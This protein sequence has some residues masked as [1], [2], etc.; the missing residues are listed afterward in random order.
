[1]N[2]PVRRRPRRAKGCSAMQ[3][4]GGGG[5]HYRG[6]WCCSAGAPPGLQALLRRTR[7]EIKVTN[8]A[9]QLSADKGR[10]RHRGCE[11]ETRG[12]DA[13]A[14][15]VSSCLLMVPADR[16]LQSTHSRA[17]N[18]DSNKWAHM[19]AQRQR[20][21]IFYSFTFFF[22]LSLLKQATQHNSLTVKIYIF[23]VS[24]R[25]LSRVCP[26]AWSAC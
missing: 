1:M 18:L 6:L 20:H 9:A 11:R 14:T 24:D 7:S 19:L 16:T 12:L 4:T 3:W 17:L 23:Q 25:Q 26:S 15:A 10:K 5:V 22:F 2:Q 13:P 8:A 21:R